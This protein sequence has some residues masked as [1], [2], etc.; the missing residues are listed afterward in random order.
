MELISL[1]SMSEN[2]ME[3]FFFK[4]GGNLPFRLFFCTFGYLG[5][6]TFGISLIPL[7]I[8]YLLQVGG[9]HIT[10]FISLFKFQEREEFD[11]VWG[12]RG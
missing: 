2:L 10:V 7:G 1:I 9:I 11:P 5:I 6:N 3:G 4:K 12:K 8:T